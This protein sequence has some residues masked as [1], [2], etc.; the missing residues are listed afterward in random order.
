M[1]EIYPFSV[2]RLKTIGFFLLLLLLKF[3]LLTKVL[4]AYR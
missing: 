4:V 2:I 3:F 1:I